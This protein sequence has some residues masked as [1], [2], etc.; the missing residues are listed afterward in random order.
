MKILFADVDIKVVNP[1]KRGFA[2]KKSPAL[3]DSNSKYMTCL[4]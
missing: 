1:E 4:I 3:F 2:Q